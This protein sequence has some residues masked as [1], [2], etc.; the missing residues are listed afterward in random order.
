MRPGFLS[1]EGLACF[2]DKQEIDLRQLDLFAISGPTGA[3]KSTLLDAI[4]FALYGEVPRVTTQ[5]RSQMISAS[6]DRASVLLEFDVGT[7]R[8]RIA[9]ALRRSGGHTVRLEKHDGR[10]FNINLADQIKPASEKVVEILGLDATAFVQAVV[11][12]QGEFARFL[13]AQPRDRRNMLRSLLRLDVY[14]RMR[15][16]AQST[17]SSKKSAVDSH[18]KV[19]ADEYVGID[20][21]TLTSLETRHADLSAELTS[22]RRR[23]DDAHQ[24]LVN[25][26]VQHGKTIELLQFESKLRGFQDVADE[27]DHIQ[28]QVAAAKRASPLVSHLEEAKRAAE[29]ASHATLLLASAEKEDEAARL[30]SDANSATL[31]ALEKEADVIPDL[32]KKIERLNQIV[33]R[34]PEAQ[35]LARTISRQNENLDRLATEIEALDI[36]AK[37]A[38]AAQREHTVAIE[39]AQTALRSSGFDADLYELLETVRAQAVELG[40]ARR[41]ARETK[42][43]AATKQEEFDKLHASL[44]PLEERQHVT[45]TLVESA[46]MAAE[47]AEAARHA[48]HHHNVANYLRASLRPNEPCPV[49]EQSVASPPATGVATEVAEAEKALAVAKKLLV[50]AEGT[51]RA[52]QEALT[53]AQANLAAEQKNLTNLVARDSELEANVG[54][55]DAQ[56]RA[57]LDGHAPGAVEFIEL[58]I[59]RTVAVLAASHKAHTQ[60]TRQLGDAEQGRVKA[61][62]DE[63]NARERLAEKLTARS[64]IVQERQS[65]QDRLAKLREEIA[66]VTNSDEPAAEAAALGKQ[67][68]SFESSLKFASNEAMNAKI[69]M[70][71]AAEALRQTINAADKA[72]GDAANRAKRRDEEIARTGFVDEPAVRAAV[73]DETKLEELVAR[74]T[75]YEQDNHA[76]EQQVHALRGVLGDIRVGDQELTNAEHTT[77]ALNTDVETLHGEQK[78]LEEQIG[79]MKQRLERSKTMRAELETEER[80]LRVFSHLASDLRSDKFQAYILEEAFIELVKG[81]SMRLVSLTSERYSLLFRDGDILVVDN[82]NAGETRISAT[83]SGGE[84]FLTSLSLALEL[85]DQVQRAAGAVNL[86]SLFIDEGFGTLDPDTLA[87]VSETIQSLRVGGR[88]VGI[89]TH[90]P[91]LRDE[92]SQQII[93]TKHQGFSTVAVNG[94]G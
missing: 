63:I 58:W 32:R 39:S 68:E 62:G 90:I 54:A 13:K 38:L 25:L 47:D 76:V 79:R 22:I 10:G 60:A 87:V 77:A 42:N 41:G 59:G 51:A 33:G 80:A 73:L 91:D 53:R 44:A 28:V 26:R 56:L 74:I 8:Y 70:T 17:A 88:M 3:G 14:E 65:S 1:I 67:I 94:L 40:V 19:L 35:E 31:E 12:P 45:A 86:D 55:A 92:F 46:R 15:D 7:D 52:T 34:L 49:C 24:S 30:Q 83:L 27:L 75:K 6:R 66:S 5:N 18:R 89:I 37:A 84:T 2:K 9:R 20:D 61:H 4:T 64:G 69:R 93:V 36:A 82:D 78:A 43:A 48:A 11:L 81:A 16:Q 23:R 71:R 72:A 21:E 85:S 57:T 50:Q 29:A